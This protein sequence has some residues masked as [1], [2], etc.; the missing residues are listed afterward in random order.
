MDCICRILNAAPFQNMAAAAA[1]ANE[2]GVSRSQISLRSAEDSRRW[3]E[4]LSQNSEG[5]DT[6]FGLHVSGVEPFPSL[7]TWPKLKNLHHLELRGIDFRDS[8]VSPIPFFD[9]YGSSIDGLALEGL[10]FQEMDELLALIM[11]F[12]NLVSLTVHD[13]EWGGDEELDD[14]EIWSSS[15]SES[16]DETHKHTAQSGD[17]CAITNTGSHSMD[18]RDIDLPALKHLS[19]RGCSSTIA[20]HFTRMPSGLR[21]VRLEISWEDEHLHPLGEMIEACAPSLSE[22]SISGAF[23]TGRPQDCWDRYSRSDPTY[24]QNATTQSPCHPV[25]ILHPSISTE[26][27]SSSMSHSDQLYII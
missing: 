23:H 4:I 10:R 3:S 6:V 13:V 20:R 5:P 11:P 19:L 9:A 18:D 2:V 25:P 12:K 22:L 26:S 7:L 16:E 27:T 8:R 15:E 1:L 24:L 21:L 14:D 17:C